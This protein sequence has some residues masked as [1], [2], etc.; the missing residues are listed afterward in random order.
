MSFN[1]SKRL[2][3]FI[4]VPIH[5]VPKNIVSFRQQM[6]LGKNFFFIF[7]ASIISEFFSFT[8]NTFYSIL[9]HGFPFKQAPF[10][11]QQHTKL[12]PIAPCPPDQC[13]PM[14]N[15]LKKHANKVIITE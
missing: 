3:G 2:V 14:I 10:L 4:G 15:L 5:N 11:E 8:S 13:T 9:G 6:F 12:I 1:N 7:L